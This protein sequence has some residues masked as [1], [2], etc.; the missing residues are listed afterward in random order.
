MWRL[1]RAERQRSRLFDG[2]DVAIDFKGAIFTR[3]RVW[4]SFHLPAPTLVARKRRTRGIT[5]RTLTLRRQ[6]REINLTRGG[7]T[8]NPSGWDVPVMQ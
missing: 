5:S 2:R 6:A 8:I 7:S 4:L 1:P 3:A